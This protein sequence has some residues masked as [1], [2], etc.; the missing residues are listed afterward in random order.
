MAAGK[1]RKST[2]AAKP[3]VHPAD[4]E[5]EAAGPDNGAELPS[6]GG[7]ATAAIVPATTLTQA[8]R[9][10]PPLARDSYARGRDQS[11]QLVTDFEAAI[12]ERPVLSLLKAAGIG[13]V[14]GLIWR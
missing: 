7:A 14:I 10:V 8:I 1:K 4:S 13:F 5:R 6:G 2:A 3:E 12:R 9:Q 11:H